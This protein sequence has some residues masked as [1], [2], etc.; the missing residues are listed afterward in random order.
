[1]SKSTCGRWRGAW[2]RAGWRHWYRLNG[3]I[4][5]RKAIWEKT[6]QKKLKFSD[7]RESIRKQIRPSCWKIFRVRFVF[8][9]FRESSEIQRIERI[10]GLHSKCFVK[11]LPPLSNFIY[12]AKKKKNCRAR[13][14]LGTSLALQCYAVL[15]S[16]G[17]PP[18]KGNQG[19]YSVSKQP[20]HTQGPS[21]LNPIRHD[22]TKI[23]GF[24]QLGW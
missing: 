16:S 22:I 7:S 5:S 10:F 19:Q 20:R 24:Y 18:I 23:I 8:V 11:E 6:L 1:V 4:M 13:K 15:V 14:S 12:K 2:A 9:W 21:Q 3:T 17:F